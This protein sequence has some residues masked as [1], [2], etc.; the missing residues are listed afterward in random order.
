MLVILFCRKYLFI[1]TLLKLETIKNSTAA[2]KEKCGK[3][4][5]ILLHLK[6]KEKACTYE[7][8]DNYIK[9]RAR[10]RPPITFFKFYFY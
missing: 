9:G 7:D 3:L 2:F 6:K 8:K 4:I 5:M 10:K 1:L